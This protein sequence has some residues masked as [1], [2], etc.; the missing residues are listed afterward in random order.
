MYCGSCSVLSI[1]IPDPTLGCEA[2]CG[3]L[4][5]PSLS[6]AP[7]IKGCWNYRA[8][9]WALY[10]CYI[11]CKP[12]QTQLRSRTQETG[13]G[14]HYG[15]MVGPKNGLLVCPIR[16]AYIRGIQGPGGIKMTPTEGLC[17]PCAV[18]GSGPYN[19]DYN[20]CTIWA[21]LLG[22]WKVQDKPCMDSKHNVF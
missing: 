9:V 22:L 10:T 13:K 18:S 7:W 5:A 16:G 21:T 4:H 3:K 11:P 19:L 2:L 1:N 6:P 8:V 20:T 15:P 12:L 17:E 14:P